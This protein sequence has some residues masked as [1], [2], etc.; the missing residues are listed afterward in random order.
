AP[1]VPP[2]ELCEAG[3]LVR[4]DK[5]SDT[6]VLYDL[7]HSP[8]LSPLVSPTTPS[9]LPTLDR[10]RLVFAAAPIRWTQWVEIWQRDGRRTADGSTREDAHRPWHH[11]LRSPT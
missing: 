9:P 5:L 6:T 10:Q 1:D 4:P 8:E 2:Y 11:A 3:L 7:R